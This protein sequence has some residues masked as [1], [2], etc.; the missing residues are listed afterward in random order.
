MSSFLDYNLS[1]Y[2]IISK[3]HIFLLQKKLSPFLGYNLRI[4][5][6]TSKI[7]INTLIFRLQSTYSQLTSKIN[8]FSVSEETINREIGRAQPGQPEQQRNLQVRGVGRGAELFHRVGPRR[9][10]RSR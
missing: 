3:I 6:L 10:D 7:H 9:Y 4:F 1:I 5:S 8:Y 2:L